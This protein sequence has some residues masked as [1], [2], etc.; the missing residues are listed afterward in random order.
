MSTDTGVIPITAAAN[1]GPYSDIIHQE[2]LQAAAQTK[3]A[4]AEATVSK[5]TT[6]AAVSTETDPA[7]IAG[8]TTTTGG[9]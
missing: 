9:M 8:S 1:I 7:K 2:E 6:A 4:A 3:A 5:A